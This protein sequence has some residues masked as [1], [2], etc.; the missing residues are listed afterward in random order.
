M[1]LHPL[2]EYDRR[3]A[4]CMKKFDQ[5][6]ASMNDKSK[7]FIHTRYRRLLRYKK[8][9]KNNLTQSKRQVA[10][11]MTEQ[12]HREWLIGHDLYNQI[13]WYLEEGEDELSKQILLKKCKEIFHN[14]MSEKL[15]WF[16]EGIIPDH[17][18]T[19]FASFAKFEERK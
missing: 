10:F 3:I 12:E 5:L 18:V 15:D 2:I 4:Y 17:P 7:N 19:P 8:A 9:V 1:K 16:D 6:Q 11:K 13:R 14:R